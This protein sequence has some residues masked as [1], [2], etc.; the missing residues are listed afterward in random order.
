[1]KL[2]LC[3]PAMTFDPDWTFHC[4]LPFLNY[5]ST[6]G[7]SVM[8]SREVARANLSLARERLIMEKSSDCDDFTITA[9]W[10][11]KVDYDYILWIDADIKFGPE[12][13][14]R[15]VADDKDIITGV[16]P[17]MHSAETD[18]SVSISLSASGMD[19]VSFNTMGGGLEECLVCGFG[20]IL[21]KRGVFECIPR[22]W[23]PCQRMTM[24]GRDCMPG[25]DIAFC[26]KARE[27]GFQVWVDR[28]VFLPH[29]K[30]TYLM[31]PKGTA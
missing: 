7:I 9:P 16:Y 22:P 13:F 5:C 2:V 31:P 25:E 4:L 12:D 20:F 24:L 30:E 3:I 14:E 28:G 8:V 1:M 11:G 17:M 6:K 23:F 21:I 15:L 29:K 10:N 18:G 26:L 19:G 27:A